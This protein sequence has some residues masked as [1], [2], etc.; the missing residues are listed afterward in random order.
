MNGLAANGFG[1]AAG[2][3]WPAIGVI[4]R[5]PTQSGFAAAGKEGLVAGIGRRDT[6]TDFYKR[7]SFIII[8]AANFLRSSVVVAFAA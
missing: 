6:G 8:S 4:R 2:F 7:E 3:G 1:T 5:G